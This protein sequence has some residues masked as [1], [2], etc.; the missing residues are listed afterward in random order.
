MN[1]VRFMALTVGLTLVVTTMPL[2]VGALLGS[3]SAAADFAVMAEGAGALLAARGLPVIDD[4]G[5]FA[6]TRL[7]DAQVTDLFVAGV[8]VAPVTHETG[9]GAYRFDG[10]DGDDV[11]PPEL[12]ADG[13]DV[14]LVQFRGPVRAEWRDALDAAATVFEYLPQHTFIARFSDSA[15]AAA[16]GERD[17]TMFLGPYHVGY[18]LAPQLPADG[19]A[20]VTILAFK[21]ADFATV[22][23]AVEAIGDVT[24]FSDTNAFDNVV[25][26]FVPAVDLARVAALP[27]V[28][29]IEPSYD[30]GAGL[31]NAQ[32]TAIT[33]TGALNDWRVSALGVD[34]SSQVTSVCDTGVN[35]TGGGTFS[36]VHEM[37]ADGTKT[38]T[39]NTPNPT[40]RKVYLYYAPIE[41]GIKGDGDDVSGHG[42]HTAG[43]LA[44]DAPPYGAR[45]GN[46]GFAIRAKLAICDITT[47][48]SF[49][50]LS[51]YDNYW[52]PAYAA[53][54][55]VNSNSW[56]STH[57]NEYTEKARMHDAYVWTHRDFN[58]LRSMG[59]TGPTGSIRPE[60][61]A[62]SA[63]GVG[64]TNNGNGMEDLASFSTRG[65]TADNRLKPTVVAPGACLTS[66]Y[67]SG[68]TSYSCLSG[69]SMSTPSVAGAATLVRDYFVKGYHGSGTAGSA[70]S[71]NPSHALVRAVLIA[72]GRE[73]TGQGSHPGPYMPWYPAQANHALLTGARATVMNMLTN[74]GQGPSFPNGAQGWGRVT[75]DDALYFS[76]DA[77]KLFV[78]DEGAGLATG[79]T[80]EFTVTVADATVPLKIVLAWS[81]FPAAA[82]ANPAIVND[83]DL[84][85]LSPVPYNGNVLLNGQSAPIP[86]KDGT[87]VEEAVII[88]QPIAG[89]YTIKVIGANVANGP[90]PFALVATGGIV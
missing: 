32:S 51:N 72:S 18:K 34:G 26:A 19:V 30:E 67:L 1:K 13:T 48:F 7:T 68:A 66:S 79:G 17:E 14:Y 31:D 78:A 62:K 6:T 11:V 38:L 41:N 39:L 81:D 80:A 53:G 46:D 52:N 82:N 45:N 47:G 63:F 9:R 75:L 73:M 83:L 5:A 49:N 57:T 90:Q 21:D 84:T 58:V 2:G 65:P 59:N 43:T 71:L 15:A 36:M 27:G 88:K 61:V 29:F 25:K 50:I 16:F 35:T 37:F 10:R 76:G 55:R 60:A 33:M 87:N 74:V 85:V 70:P 23:D 89:T 4:Y 64:A 8:T 42:T 22:L 44:G 54:A 12:R 28:S 56:G 3:A 69:T 86:L 77:A 20:H 40:H 24:A